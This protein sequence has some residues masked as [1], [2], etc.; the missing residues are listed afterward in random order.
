MRRTC[1]LGTRYLNDSSIL[2]TLYNRLRQQP[3]CLDVSADKG[4]RAEEVGKQKRFHLFLVR[5]NGTLL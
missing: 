2:H 1:T 4:H 3:T 5:E